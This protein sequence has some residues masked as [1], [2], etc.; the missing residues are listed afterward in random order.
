VRDGGCAADGAEEVITS[1]RGR[2]GTQQSDLHGSIEADVGGKPLLD[3]S[4]AS[5]ADLE[6]ESVRK[7]WRHQRVR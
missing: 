1:L 2:V 5:E 7:G 6:A 3:V 4:I